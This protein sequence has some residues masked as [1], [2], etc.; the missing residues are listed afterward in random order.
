VPY[1]SPVGYITLVQVEY[2]EGDMET[3][4]LP[5]T[6]VSGADE[7]A[8]WEELPQLIVARVQIAATGE[9]G[10]LYDA[11]RDP[12]FTRVLLES[13]AH[14]RTFRGTESEVQA[15]PLRSFP[16]FSKM[17]SSGAIPSGESEGEAVL[18]FEP[19]VTTSDQS[20]TNITYGNR[21]T[22]KF[23][24]R[25]EPGINPDLEIGRFLTEHVSLARAP[26]VV[27]AL[28][29]AQRQSEP[30]TLGV[31]RAFV[32][33]QGDAWEYTQQA[34]QRFFAQVLAH[35]REQG[36]P[37][38]PPLPHRHV[39]NLAAEEPPDMVR[40]LLGDYR[41]VARLLGQRTAELHVALAQDA[42][43]P[44]FAPE[45]FTDFFQRPFYYAMLGLMDRDFQ[46]LQRQLHQLP[47]AVRDDARRVI[48]LEERVRSYFLPFRDRKIT[49]MRIRCH[50]N[51]H[52]GKVLRADDDFVISDFEGEPTR[53]IEERRLK[54]SPL[55]DV[56]SMLRSFHYAVAVA[57][58]SQEPAPA[59]TGW[60]HFWYMWVSAIF[61]HSYNETV[62]QSPLLIQTHDEFQLLLDA[63]LL[64]K[65]FYELGYEV[66]HRPDWVGIPI[67]GILQ[68]LAMSAPEA[69]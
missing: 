34:L 22:L 44:N 57:L 14:H 48:A 38:P 33:N 49:A 64:E 15:F 36:T 56:A 69:E 50:G 9:S 53:S 41:E 7:A 55:R 4:V 52:L 26:A 67:Q 23:F 28:E 58:F 54:G 20:N 42:D 40:S 18:S 21:F 47:P 1:E 3:Y 12:G 59:L 30:S 29:Y 65:A 5:F 62:Q 61:L 66:Q 10:I 43:D 19:S 17:R 37:E 31:L 63:Y 8:I 27:G 24:R 13:I 60:A 25:V 35:Q 11:L 68:L 51:Y 39:L 6:F 32:P 16:L 2:S 46:F 45:P